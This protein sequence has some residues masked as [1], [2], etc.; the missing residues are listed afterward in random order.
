MAVLDF[1]S[2]Q[3]VNSHPR[4]QSVLKEVFYIGTL[5]H[6]TRRRATIWPGRNKFYL[7]SS[8]ISLVLS[9]KLSEAGFL[10]PLLTFPEP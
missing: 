10:D 8:V 4:P 1:S 2:L 9:D 3:S 5:L 7:I 6:L